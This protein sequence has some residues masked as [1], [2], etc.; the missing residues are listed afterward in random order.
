MET[1]RTIRT[2]LVLAWCSLLEIICIRVPHILAVTT[3]PRLPVTTIPRVVF[4]SLRV[5]LLWGNHSRR[6]L[7]EEIPF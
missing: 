6:C 5:F 3:I 1:S 7:H 4:I 2:P